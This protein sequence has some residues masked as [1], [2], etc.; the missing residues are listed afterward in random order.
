MNTRKIGLISA[1]LPTYNRGYLLD[2]R[3]QQIFKQSYQN[4]ELIIVNDGSSD[5]TKEILKD[6]KYDARIIQIHM[7]ENSKS[8]SVPRNIGISWANGEFIAPIDDDN[9][10]FPEKFESLVAPLK[11]DGSIV[12]SYGRRLNIDLSSSNPKAQSVPTDVCWNPHNGPGIDNGQMLYRA[13]CYD[14]VPLI[15]PLNACDYYTAK[16]I[17]SL[18]PFAFVDKDVCIYAHHSKNRAK[19]QDFRPIDPY[20][21]E[22]YFCKKYG[23][24]FSDTQFTI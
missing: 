20:H 8:V 24:K 23:Y 18:G 14:K 13:D 15:F 19:V 4:W 10:D 3:L 1:I 2:S 9:F 22:Q 12:M 6:Y 17:Y 11:A 7:A 21:Y 16:H 5:D